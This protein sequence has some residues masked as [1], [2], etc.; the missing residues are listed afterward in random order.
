[1]GVNPGREKGKEVNEA[2]SRLSR[3]LC[4]ATGVMTKFPDL[5]KT[6]GP[7][8]LKEYPVEPVEVA[9]ITPSAQ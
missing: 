9:I 4:G 6:I 3:R 5:G 7:P 8:Q 2:G 1:M